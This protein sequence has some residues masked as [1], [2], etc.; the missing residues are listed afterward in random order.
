M[1][2]K[3]RILDEQDVYS[4]FFHLKRYELTFELFRGGLSRE[5]VRECS[6]TTGYVVAAL[7]YDPV[8]EEFVLVEQFRVGAMA[9][10][11][12]PW[13]CEIVAGFMDVVGETPEECVQR[14]LAEEI[15]TQAKKL[16][17]VDTYFTGPGGSAGQVHL[18]FAEIDSRLVTKYAGLLTEGEDILVH[19]VPYEEVFRQLAQG[20]ISNATMILAVQAF[21]LRKV[22]PQFLLQWQ[23]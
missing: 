16:E 9:A 18:F 13:Q 15:G 10:G 12:H 19:R 17:L 6:T 7:P 2:Y 5:V 23:R 11:V 8:R 3:F 1:K 14:E 21:I 4:G 20:E 22:Q